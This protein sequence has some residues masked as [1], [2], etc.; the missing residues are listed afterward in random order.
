MCRRARKVIAEGL[1]GRKGKEECYNYI[2]IS[3]FKKC[4]QIIKDDSGS[5]GV[6]VSITCLSSPD[7][8]CTER[9]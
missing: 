9:K 8:Q 7:V 3:N 5:V 4:K 2:I 1:E 6:N